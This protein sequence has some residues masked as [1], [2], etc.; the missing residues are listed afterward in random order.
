M[1]F[2]VALGPPILHVGIIT[3]NT[4]MLATWTCFFIGNVFVGF[5]NPSLSSQVCKA[6]G[7]QHDL[8]LLKMMSAFPLGSPHLRDSIGGFPY[9]GKTMS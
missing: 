9:N 8:G 1:V 7:V 4:A 5:V 2:E 3:F 6:A